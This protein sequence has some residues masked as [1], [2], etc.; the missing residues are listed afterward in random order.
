[1]SF[2]D[3]QLLR[4]RFSWNKLILSFYIGR[5]TI[6]S[7]HTTNDDLLKD[8]NEIRLV[9]TSLLEE[10]NLKVGDRARVLLKGL[11]FLEIKLIL[12]SHPF[13]PHQNSF[14]SI[15]VCAVRCRL[16]IKE[17]IRLMRS[18]DA[19]LWQ[20]FIRFSLQKQEKR[21]KHSVR[22]C[23]WPIRRCRRKL[24]TDH[25]QQYSIPMSF[26]PKLMLASGWR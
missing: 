15:P 1:M 24:S 8:W 22:V 21:T 4:V 14:H 6:T 23:C 25:L 9:T 18:S 20:Q 7:T 13:A 10:L 12:F 2:G 17:N 19:L 5:F 26:S 11:H 3:T 16:S